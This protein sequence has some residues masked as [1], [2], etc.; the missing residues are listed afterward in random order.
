[1]YQ[2]HKSHFDTG[3]A[4]RDTSLAEILGAFSY[5]LDLTEGQPAG[6]SQRACWIAMRLGHAIGLGS[7]ALGSLYY[8][9][10][11]KDLGCSAN[12]ARVAQVFAG[13]DVSL[14]RDFKLIGPDPE[15]FG[16]FVMTKAGTE[17]NAVEGG[18]EGVIDNLL[19]NAGPIMCD[20]IDTRCTR[21]ADIARQ[22][23]FSDDVAT[24][25]AALDEHWDG[26]GLPLGIAGE[27]I[28]LPSRI[29]LLAQLAD[30]FFMT[31]GG[32]AAR[33]EILRRS[34]SWFDPALVKPFMAMTAEPD[35]WRA[36]GARTLPERLS[37]LEPEDKRL[38]VD[39][40]WLAD[41][42]SA[43]GQVI[44]AKSAFTSGHSTRV[45]QLT[46]AIAAQL[47]MAVED[48]VALS[49]AAMLHDVG[50]LGVSSRILEKPGKLDRDEWSAMQRHADLTVDI[51]SRV[52]AMRD[53]AMIAG[54]HH[55]RLDGK[56]YP[57]QL[58]ASMIALET[59]IVTAADIFDALTADRPYRAA[60][61]VEEALAI[62]AC[63]VGTAID[64]RCFAALEA[65][66]AD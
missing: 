49:R 50:K 22:L 42:A 35:F 23:R 48:R 62:M 43:F 40:G 54:A 12:A 18:R 39:D 63:D 47:G 20:I 2:N 25:I 15:H 24:A 53:L 57:L 46:N 13:N 29:A 10:L 51:L 27:A 52:G 14:K 45:G 28:P 58:D 30:V 3:A 31:E 38:P 17:A 32:L 26:S 61:P 5:A 19:A 11:L 33:R 37:M 8:A 55:E 36:L 44:D 21:G 66:T 4:A 56:G 6:H 34:G 1:M 59:R 16:N 41:I 7:D 9:V 65:I 60:L 64:P